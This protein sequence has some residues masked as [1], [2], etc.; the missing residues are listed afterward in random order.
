MTSPLLGALP[1]LLTDPLPVCLPILLSAGAN[2]TWW[3]VRSSKL[4]PADLPACG[5]GPLLNFIGY[6]DAPAKGRRLLLE[7]AAPANNTTAAAAATDGPE[8]VQALVAGISNYCSREGW[9]VEQVSGKRTIEPPDLQA[10]Q[11]AARQAGRMR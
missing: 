5:F 4:E 1:P 11:A 8:K 10:A 6:W 9:L 2:T 7:S 3:N